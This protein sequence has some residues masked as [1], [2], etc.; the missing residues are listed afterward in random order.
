MKHR[1]APAPGEN[2]A[3]LLRCADGSLYAGWTNDLSRRLAA[4]NAGTGAKYTRGR[5][6]VCLAYAR[7][8]ATQGEAM[9]AEAALK[10]LPKPEKEALCRRWAAEGDR[11]G[12]EQG[13]P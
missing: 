12:A 7:S 5:G 1:E 4:H 6:P 3:Y 10:R 2:W 11:A 8:Y 9:A 13:R